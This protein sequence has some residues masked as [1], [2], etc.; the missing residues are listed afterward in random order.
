MLCLFCNEPDRSYKP[1]PDKDFICGSCVQLLLRADQDDLKRA[2]AKAIDMEY[3]RKAEALKLFL[4]DG[5]NYEQR[6]PKS[7]KRGRHPN[8]TRIDRVARSKKERIKRSKVS[9]P[10]TV[11]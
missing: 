5:E 3:K 2:Y 6:K 1:E 11:L 10:I 7:K 9:T 8:R 4:H